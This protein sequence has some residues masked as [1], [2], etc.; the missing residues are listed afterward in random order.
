MLA[1]FS[2][3][4]HAAGQR[5]HKELAAREPAGLGAKTFVV[6]AQPSARYS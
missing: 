4:R 1:L 2:I 5:P 3:A 6:F